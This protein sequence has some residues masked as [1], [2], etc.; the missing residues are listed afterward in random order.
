MLKLFMDTCQ[1]KV[2]VIYMHSFSLSYQPFFHLFMKIYVKTNQL[3]AY[4][5]VNAS[6]SLLLASIKFS[7]SET[8]SCCLQED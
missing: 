5:P 4:K 7:L 3:L 8:C 6:Y 1:A 2:C